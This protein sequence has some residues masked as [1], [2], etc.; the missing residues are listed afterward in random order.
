MSKV[1][2]NRVVIVTGGASGIGRAAAL[3]MAENGA[4]VVVADRDEAGGNKTTDSIRAKGNEATFVKVDLAVEAEVEN[5][6]KAAVSSYGGLDGA[7]NNAGVAHHNKLVHD[8]TGEEWGRVI[9]I[10][11]TAVFYCMKY[12]IAEMLKG[13]R[14]SIVNTSS[15]AGMVAIPRC[16]EYVAAKHGVIGLTKAAALDYGEHNIRV[17]AILPGFTATEMV[18]GRYGDPSMAEAKAKLL[19][20]QPMGRFGEP[21][22]LG[23]SALWLLSDAAS[24]VTG[25]AIPVDGGFLAN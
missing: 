25:A 4:K 16:S 19:E 21:R 22:E 13:G 23:E 15:G 6:V 18:V 20:R 17:N 1:L 12:E 7:F 11:L 5:M 9:A 8:L 2:N 3:V 24:F 10:D 14:G